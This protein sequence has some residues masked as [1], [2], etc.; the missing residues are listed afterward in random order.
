MIVIAL[1]GAAEAVMDT[2]QFHFHSSVL[3]NLNRTFWD[4]FYSWKNKWT[5]IGKKRRERFFGSSTFLVFLTDGWHMFKF[6]RNVMLF[7]AIGLAML[8]GCGSFMEMV[9]TVLIG[10]VLFGIFFELTFRVLKL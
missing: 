5:Y 10:R 6:V 4:P 1:A 9:A 8:I 2:I 3:S 7:A